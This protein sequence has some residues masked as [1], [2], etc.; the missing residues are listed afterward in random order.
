MVTHSGWLR[1]MALTIR[2]PSPFSL[3]F[4]SDNNASKRERLI[5]DMASATLA[6][7]VTSNPF[8]CRIAGRVSRMLGS[9][10]TKSI[11]LLDIAF[12]A[13]LG[14]I[15]YAGT[16]DWCNQNRYN[17]RRFFRVSDGEQ[18]PKLVCRELVAK[19][20]AGQNWRAKCSNGRGGTGGR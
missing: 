9:S 2:K 13:V 14:L 11:R 16:Q 12:W 4:K 8:S 18:K 15:C 1:R 5:S 17:G 19:A 6:A 3:I 10:S 7:V 20:D